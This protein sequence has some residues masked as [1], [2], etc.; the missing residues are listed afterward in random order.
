MRATLAA[1]AAFLT[2]MLAAPAASAQVVESFRVGNWDVEAHYSNGRFAFC[3]AT[4]EYEYG[5]ELGFIEGVGDD[6]KSYFGVAWF[7][8]NAPLGVQGQQLRIQMRYENT[9][10][11]WMDATLMTPNLAVIAIPRGSPHRERL[12]RRYQVWFSHN[13]AEVGFRLTQSSAAIRAIGECRARH[14]R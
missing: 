13:G 4:T 14:A 3:L 6:G 12:I 2:V 10:Y 11:Q 5:D 1:L 8:A 9:A 7:A